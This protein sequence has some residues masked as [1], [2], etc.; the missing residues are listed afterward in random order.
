MSKFQELL[1]QVRYIVDLLG[2]EEDVQLRTDMIEGSTDAYEWMDWCVERIYAENALIEQISERQRR[3]L[4]RK[5]SAEA[6][7]RSLREIIHVLMNTTGDKKVKRPEFTLS[8]RKSP[9]KVLVVDDSFLPDECVEVV[10][11]PK[12]SI[13][14]DFLASG[15]T[16]QG[17]EVSSGGETISI[18]S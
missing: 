7:A 14:K 1:E 11:K 8:V 2:D 12:L 5:K 4:Q 9:D 6:R 17:V 18:R 13:I 3:L 15:K 16:I 10:R